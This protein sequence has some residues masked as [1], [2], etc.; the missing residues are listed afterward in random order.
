MIIVGGKL[1]GIEAAYLARQAGWQ[2]SLLD[3]DPDVPARGLADSFFCCDV[4]RH[5][6]DLSLPFQEV[7]LIIP[8]LENQEALI[9]LK[10]LAERL[11]IPIAFD[12]EAY[13]VTSSKM[14]SDR[15]FRELGIPSP[16]YWPGCD[17]PLIIKPSGLSGSEGIQ[18]I[19]NR[20]EL[21]FL[22][23]KNNLKGS[24][25]VIQ[26]YLE[27]PS[28]SLEILGFNGN[29]WP[30]Q[31]TVIEVDRTY[32]CKRVL[33]PTG[34]SEPLRNDL[35]HMATAVAKALNLQ[36]I[37]DVEVILHA[38]NLRMLEIDARLPSQTPTVVL[39]STGINM[40]DY[41]SKI[42]AEGK[43]PDMEYPVH[44]RSV[45]LEHMHVTPHAME[46]CGEH[47][48]A[49]AG[50]LRHER[51]FFGADEALTDFNSNHSPWVA[52][53]ILTG[54]DNQEV[55]RKRRRFIK[56]IRAEF[57]LPECLESYPENK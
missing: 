40:L 43:A 1:Q 50:A 56:N 39:K 28:Y 42:Y 55:H 41:L 29:F 30:L 23:A 54:N 36:G 44:E 5:E 26:E 16:R 4:T 34:L 22:Q 48:M 57:G 17:F 9:S 45:I 11:D 31:P 35:T 8:A 25:W 12:A 51:D 18:K 47:I 52:T 53:L 37:M 49:E 24:Q 7:S 14:K 27:G 6:R 20:E 21:A 32:D 38:G 3:K 2:V 19:R 33:A 10:V 15:L 13:A 46:V